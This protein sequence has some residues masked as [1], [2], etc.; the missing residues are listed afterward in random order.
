MPNEY[1][2][3]YEKKLE[4]KEFNRKIG[5]FTDFVNKN[6][7]MNVYGHLLNN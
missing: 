6:D 5:L 2:K 7:C 1:I 3:I 4:K